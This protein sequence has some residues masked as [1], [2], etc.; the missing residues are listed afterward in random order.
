MKFKF[1]AAAAYAVLAAS[2]AKWDALVA[3]A[4]EAGITDAAS[5]EPDA[6]LQQLTEGTPSLSTSE[7]LTVA[8]ETIAERDVEITRL[9]AEV[10]R[11]T[12]ELNA[13]P[14]DLPA[15]P[16]A[17][18]ELPPVGAPVGVISENTPFFDAVQ[19]AAEWAGIGKSAK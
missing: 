9:N 10:E 5:L 19:Q 14:G 18:T 16:K 7:D 15:M 13:K 12:A 8:N 1:L 11:L 3:S 4:V 2:A 17:N 6:L